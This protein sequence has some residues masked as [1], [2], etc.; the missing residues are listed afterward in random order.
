MYTYKTLYL[1][2]TNQC[3]L[4]CKYCYVQQASTKMPLGVAL[5][6]ID[7][8]FSQNVNEKKKAICFFGGEPL[9]LWDE[10]LIPSIAY[11]KR[12]YKEY[13][14]KFIFTT[15][16]TLLNQEKID[17]IKE[18]GI[19]LV[20]SI[21]GTPETQNYNR[22]FTNGDPTYPIVAN[23]LKLLYNNNCKYTI[24]SV[25]YSQTSNNFYN[26][27]LHLAPYCTEHIL[28]MPDFLHPWSESEKNIFFSEIKKVSNY[29]LDS[30]KNET[31]QVKLRDFDRLIKK[32]HNLQQNKIN[33][34]KLEYLCQCGTPN[35]HHFAVSPNGNI[36][37]CQDIA[38][39][40]E[41]TPFHIGNIYTGFDLEKQLKLYTYLQNNKKIGDMSC[42]DCS[43]YAFCKDNCILI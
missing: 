14:T 27:I 31:P 6:A 32:H 42:K 1:N 13:N 4:A 9:L 16:G 30:W 7:F 17:T 29:Y 23:N 18:Y 10:V 22:T 40:E 33:T 20:L 24:K 34:S 25:I 3:N 15:N 38:N 41:E 35:D 2:L 36:Y 39:Y 12:K 43:A 5:D 11:S 37:T 28:F 19:K 8:L 21:D 26:N